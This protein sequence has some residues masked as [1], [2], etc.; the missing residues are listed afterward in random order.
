M[1]RENLIFLN[2][3]ISDRETAISYITDM[4]DASGL[5]R[6]KSV[7]LKSVQERERVLPT[8]VGFK[9]AMPHGRSSGVR[10]PFV[11]FMKTKQEFIWDT[12][13]GNEVDLVFLIAVPE[14]NE[15]NL[16]LR[17]LSEISKKLMDEDFR[18]QLRSA[19]SEHEVF[20]MLQEINEKVMEKRL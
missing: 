20:V 1:I 6:D 5:L 9:V 12:R 14:K 10:S 15:N 16:H 7:F 11:S 18:E 3:D 8:S 2:K 4:A 17:F 19:G 13:N